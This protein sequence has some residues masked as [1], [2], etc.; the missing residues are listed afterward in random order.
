MLC[1]LAPGSKASSAIFNLPL[2]KKKFMDFEAQKMMPGYN[3][4][5]L[6]FLFKKNFDLFI[7]F[8]YQ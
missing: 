4:Y 2:S 8:F 7:L 3:N 1:K 6:N 5:I